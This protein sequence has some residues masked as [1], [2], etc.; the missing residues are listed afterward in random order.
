M[1]GEGAATLVLEEFE[2]ARARGARIHAE[3]VGYGTNSDGN[4]ITQP[5][6]GTMAQALRLAI[7]D[8]NLSVEDIGFVNGHGTAT[9]WGDIAESNATA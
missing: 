3:V 7:T 4:H 8:A 9:E 6:S 2:H 1:I 5:A